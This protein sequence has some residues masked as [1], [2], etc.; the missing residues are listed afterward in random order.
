MI[1]SLFNRSFIQQQFVPSQRKLA[2]VTPISKKSPL[3]SSN[4]LRP[5]SLT[6][7][8]TTLFEKLILKFELSGV[9]KSLIRPDQFAYKKL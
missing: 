3:T 5:I 2:N 8:I 7:I 1:M 9:L 4:Q 6:K